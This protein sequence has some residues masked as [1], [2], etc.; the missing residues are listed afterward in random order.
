MSYWR[1]HYHVIWTTRQRLPAIDANREV[2]TAR[3][4]ASIADEQGIKLHAVGMVSDHVHVAVSIP[5]R[6]SVSS[7]VQLLKGTSS[8]QLQKMMPAEMEAW[9]G[10]QPEYGVLTFGD[11]SFERIISYVKNQKDHHKNQTTWAGLEQVRGDQ[12]PSTGQT[13]KGSS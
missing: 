8:H 5:P 9:P 1:C 13:L 10:W 4:I 12:P 2:I 7:I 6:L 3:C 11:G